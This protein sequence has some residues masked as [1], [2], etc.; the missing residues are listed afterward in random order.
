M[1]KIGL[2]LSN[3]PAYSET[4]FN[5]KIKG[6]I[7]NGVEVV[8]YT[9]VNNYEFDLCKV[10]T[11]PKVYANPVLQLFNMLSVFLSLLPKLLVVKRYVVLERNEQT[12]WPNLIKKLYLNAHLL[13][14][15]LDWLHF[16]FATQAIGSELVAKAID[17][18]MAVSFRGFDI[19]VYPIKHPKCYVLLWDNVDKVH[20]ISQYL[21]DRA[22]SLGLR[23]TTVSEII[24]PAI[25]QETLCLTSKKQEN[26]ETLQLLTIARLHW[27]KGI[28]LLIETAALLKEKRVSFTWKIIGSGDQKSIERYKFHIY[29]RGL[30]N[31]VL[32]IGKLTHEHTLTQLQR[33]DIY[34]QPS[35]NEGFCNAVLEAQA[36]GKLCIATNVGGVPENII[37]TK[38]GWLVSKYDANSL[39]AKTVEVMSLSNETK[40]SI[41]TAARTRVESQFT[42]KKQQQKFVKF[43]SEV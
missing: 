7:A 20:S 26:N 33:T 34:V 19:N 12:A 31:E 2:V 27:I 25:T 9:Q 40:N 38:T 43:Y 21:L 24:T 13:K 42:I 8:L 29:E 14:A 4:F 18:K 36:L 23:K 10:V 17:A 41:R 3:T 39:V 35:L 5:S 32:L 11:G 28:D 22:Y 15:D 30:Q 1:V 37:D 6:L 16:G